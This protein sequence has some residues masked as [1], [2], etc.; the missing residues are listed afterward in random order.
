MSCSECCA[1]NTSSISQD[2]KKAT[3]TGCE[4]TLLMKSLHGHIKIMHA[5]RQLECCKV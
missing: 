1:E 5:L 3:H 4:I 2:V